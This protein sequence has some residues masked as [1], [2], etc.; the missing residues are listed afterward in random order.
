MGKNNFGK[1]NFYLKKKN[2]W[3][4]VFQKF[5]KKKREKL[6]RSGLDHRVE[7]VP[8]FVP[9]KFHPRHKTVAPRSQ[10]PHKK[11]ENIISSG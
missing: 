10:L 5:M 1:K 11:M 7:K 2:F 9:Y 6:E 4:S 3:T 8:K